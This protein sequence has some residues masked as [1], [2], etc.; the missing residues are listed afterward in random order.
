MRKRRRRSTTRKTRGGGIGWEGGGD[1]WGEGGEVGEGGEGGGAE[2]GGEGG[3]GG[4]GQSVM[5]LCTWE[6]T[7]PHCVQIHLHTMSLF[8][9]LIKTKLD[10]KTRTAAVEWVEGRNWPGVAP[11][12]PRE[13]AWGYALHLGYVRIH[14]KLG[15]DLRSCLIDS[16]F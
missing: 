2:E 15:T 9:L 4:E 11:A 8:D 7:A 10:E 1:G 13:V 3:G 12:F 6:A 16:R 14:F 5:L